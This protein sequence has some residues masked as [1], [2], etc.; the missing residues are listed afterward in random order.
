MKSQP[1]F[2]LMQ[3]PLVLSGMV[4]LLV[5]T[6]L[7]WPLM[8]DPRISPKDAQILMV[9]GVGLMAFCSLLAIGVFILAAFVRKPSKGVWITCLVVACL[10]TPSAYVIFGVPMLIYLFQSDTKAY[11]GV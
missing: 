11:Y 10:Y 9:F 1:P 2:L 6:L 8:L 5:G 3:I 4:Y 7:F